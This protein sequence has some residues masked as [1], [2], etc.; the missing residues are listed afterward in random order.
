MK[1]DFYTTQPSE[2]VE[3]EE[4]KHKNCP[5]INQEKEVDSEDGD[6]SDDA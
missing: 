3:I 1:T 2:Y 6:N 5:P 4:N